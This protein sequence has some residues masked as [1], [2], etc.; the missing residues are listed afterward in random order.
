VAGHGEHRREVVLDPAQREHVAV[1]DEQAAAPA[2]Q[3]ER[4]AELADL[5]GRQA[6]VVEH[7]RHE[8]FVPMAL[9]HRE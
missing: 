5:D 4:L 8:T 3:A 7:D 2:A 6:E 1:L 9:A